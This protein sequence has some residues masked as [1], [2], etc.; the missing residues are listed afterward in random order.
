M[1]K[2]P[3]R[4]PALARTCPGNASARFRFPENESRADQLK[5]SLAHGVI[6]KFG[7]VAMAIGNGD[8]TSKSHQKSGWS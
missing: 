6:M 2:R 1:P 8:V 3:G 7:D 5:T 4:S